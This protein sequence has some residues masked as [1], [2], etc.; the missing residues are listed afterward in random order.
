MKLKMKE[1]K[2]LLTQIE[3]LNKDILA[4]KEKSTKMD[5]EKRKLEY[6]I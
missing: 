2:T 1:K 6:E 3:K 4:E 5:F